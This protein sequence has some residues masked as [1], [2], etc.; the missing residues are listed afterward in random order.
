MESL[1]FHRGSELKKWAVLTISDRFVHDALRQQVAHIVDQFRIALLKVGIN[2]APAGSRDVLVIRND[3]DPG[4]SAKIGLISKDYPLLLVVLMKDSPPL[5]K[6][7][8][9]LG[10]VKFGIHT[11]CVVWPK[12]RK[13][14]QQY[15][16]NV[17]LKMNLKLGGTNQVVVDRNGIIGED[18]TMIVGIDVT[19]PSPGSVTNSPSVAALV[20]NVDGL[21]GQWPATLGIQQSRQEMV[22]DLGAMLKSRLSLWQVKHGKSYPDNILVYRDGVSEGQYAS[23]LKDELPLLRTAC[24]EL[25]PADLTRR[26]IPRVTIVIVGKRHQTRFYPTD[27]KKA[28]RNNANPKPGTVVDRGVTEARSWDFFMQ[29]HDSI[30]GTARPAH[31]YVVLDEIFRN[32]FAQNAANELEKL[33]H[34]LCYSQGRATKAVSYCMPAYYAHLVCNRARCYLMRLYDPFAASETSSA[35]RKGEPGNPPDAQMADITVHPRLK[36]SMFYV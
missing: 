8:K 22:A 13:D 12:F 31:Y 27:G 17:A 26:R 16:A 10:D 5:Y 33:T 14:D 11:A 15:Y 23:V 1:L 2:A 34:Q 20:A 29:A 35:P 24:T 28:A 18:K 21:L 7:I 32:R 25:Y 6:H 4:I 36:D 9:H 3:D 30:Q 19:H